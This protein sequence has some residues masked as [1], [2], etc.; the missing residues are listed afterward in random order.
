MGNDRHL[1]ACACGQT[2]FETEGAPIM[3]V[4]CHCTSCQ[5][6]GARIEA[7]P[8][9]PA[10][11]DADGG[12]GFVMQRKDRLRCIRGGT[13]LQEYRLTPESPTRRVVATCCNSAMFLEFTKGHWLSIYRN[14]FTDAPPIEQRTMVRDRPAGAP[15]LDGAPGY[16]SH[17][18]KFMWRLMKA[19][20]AMGF[21]VP[22]QI[23]G[24][25]IQ[26]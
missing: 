19:W 4:A 5:Q 9:A 8:G 22:R 3:V 18:A 2:A 11:I 6:G 17:S 25:E 26:S 23:A 24:T 16:A 10:V 15:P 20:A 7:L 21:R 14:R 13:L 12:T 1:A